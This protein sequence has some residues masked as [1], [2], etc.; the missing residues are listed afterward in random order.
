MEFIVIAVVLGLWL[1][2]GYLGRK[3]CVGR[4][5]SGGVGAVV[6]LTFGVF[7]LAV[8]WLLLPQAR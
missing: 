5:R 3:L 7:G 2:C 1:L 8:M 6:G 4:G